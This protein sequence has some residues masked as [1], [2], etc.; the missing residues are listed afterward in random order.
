MVY[1]VEPRRLQSEI[2]RDEDEENEVILPDG[3]DAGSNF[4]LLSLIDHIQH[5]NLVREVGQFFERVDMVYHPYLYKLRDE[6][7]AK[8]IRLC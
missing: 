8:Y 5:Y 7:V 3:V 2:P 6:F 4:E 1:A